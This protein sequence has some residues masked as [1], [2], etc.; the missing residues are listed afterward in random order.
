MFYG[1]GL[2]QQQLLQALL[3]QKSG[4]TV[5]ELTRTLN[6]TRTAV[7]QHLMALE[8]GG[9]VRKDRLTQTGG[10]PG[11]SYVLTE[12]GYDLFPKQYA[13]F[14]E[15]LLE[16]LREELGEKGLEKYL[17]KLGAQL[18]SSLQK[19]MQGLTQ[20]QCVDEAANILR[21]LGYSA[22]ASDKGKTI[23][24][25]NCVYHELAKKSNEVCQFDISLLT[26]LLNADIEHQSC[27]AH[28]ENCFRFKV[29]KFR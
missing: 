15:L 20:T 22:S 11:Y 1:F 14:S 13:W 5:D 25:T 8:K 18:S 3:E 23:E 26:T 9:Y 29:V 6:I 10:R 28:G 27:M 16:S 2:R 24:A 19:R 4:L 7:N 21:E 17:R 12:L